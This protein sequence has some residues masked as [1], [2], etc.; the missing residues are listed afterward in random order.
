[1]EE[2]QTKEYQGEWMFNPILW[3]I[4]VTWEDGKDF[5]YI[6]EVRANKQTVFPSRQAYLEYLKPNANKT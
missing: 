4:F 6:R 1:M 2:K 5:I 3:D